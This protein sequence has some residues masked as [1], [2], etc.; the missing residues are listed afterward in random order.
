[1]KKLLVTL[2]SILVVFTLIG[3]TKEEKQEEQE[4]VVGGYTLYEG[5][6]N[7]ELPDKAKEVF[8]NV[9]KNLTGTTYDPIALLGTQVV[10][11][12]NYAFFVREKPV[13]NFAII[14][15]YA[16]L[17]GNTEILKT[18]DIDLDAEASDKGNSDANLLGGWK[19]Y[20]GDNKCDV[21][22]EVVDALT[23]A[24]EG[25]TGASY[26]PIA[27][28]GTQVV[29]GINYSILCKETVI[30]SEPMTNYSIVIVYKNTS[31]DCE[32]SGVY[33]LRNYTVE[34]D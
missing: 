24:T 26:T 20:E 12:T 13:A 14:T 21:P 25:M 2:I 19:V 8:E 15:V 1:M 23:K 11:G 18:F 4:A 28:L 29:S 33:N 31:G 30:A 16:D 17:Q 9:T 22:D 7:A 27:L 5:E 10:S 6:Y 32:L 34:R 3:C